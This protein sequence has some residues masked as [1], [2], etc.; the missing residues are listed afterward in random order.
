M[1]DPKS[2][3]IIR[4]SAIGD[5]VFASPLI[6]ALRRRYPDAR[7]SWLV[8][9]PAAPL[10]QHNPDLD[11]L[12]V[13]PKQQWRSWWRERHWLTLWRAY[14]G[15]RKELR[16]GQFDWVIDLQGLL[17]SGWLA[18]MTGAPR[19]T[20]LGSK[21]SSGRLMTEVM[22]RDDAGV[23]IGSEYY[24]LA[25]ALGLDVSSFRMDVALSAGDERFGQ[26]FRQHHGDYAVICPFTTRP[27]K[28][29]REERW[30]GLAAQ[31][32]Q[33]HGLA[34]VMAGGPADR[35]TATR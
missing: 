11:R 10:L 9:P 22:F 29:W 28:H 6:R 1:P 13:W 19:R 15:F 14:R 5:V 31:L 16:A 35:A 8:E 7:L 20:G 33:R 18:R 26:D 25:H 34:V 24:S 3:L 32:I 21:E 12:I 23:R 2:I 30:P 4:L 17:K 27:Q